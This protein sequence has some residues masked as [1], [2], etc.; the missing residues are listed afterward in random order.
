MMV[1]HVRTREFRKAL[2]TNLKP[3]QV[4][5]DLGAGTGIW[6]LLAAKAGAGKVYAVEPNA[7]IEIGRRLAAENGLADKIEFIQGLSTDIELPQKADG[8]IS[9]LRGVIPI[10]QGHLGS[11][12]DARARLLKPGA[13]QIAEKD[14]LY[15][16]LVENQAVHDSFARPWN[17]RRFELDLRLVLPYVMNQ[18]RAYRRNPS[19][20]RTEPR[21]LATLDYRCDLETTIHAEATWQLESDLM[22][23]GAVLWFESE[24]GGG[25]RFST[26]PFLE[27]NER[28]WIYG[29]MLLPFEEP[30]A[31]KAG[32]TA[33]FQFK[34][35]DSQNGY[36]YFWQ[37][38]S[39]SER[40]R[41]STFLGQLRVPGE[42]HRISENFRPQLNRRAELERCALNLLAE[43][44]STQEVAMRL[45]EEFPRNFKDYQAA[46][47]HVCRL[48]AKWFSNTQIDDQSHS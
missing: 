3:G 40:R 9:D 25:A 32:D 4:V 37:L 2:E 45:Q 47:N 31:L 19:E 33:D 35:L 24:L 39:G 44:A 7:A 41:Q 46:L 17:D 10:I 38:E 6:A 48:G 27:P 43:G 1:D 28:A 12:V 21:E 30:L 5:L 26:C 20:R 16:C 8:V 36:Q 14:T 23:H 18:H 42:S 11:I 13:W 29:N 15:A 22:V 34:A